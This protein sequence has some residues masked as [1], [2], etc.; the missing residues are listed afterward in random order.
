MNKRGQS[1]FLSIV[2]ALAIFMIGSLFINFITP[3]ITITRDSTHLDCSNDDISDGNKL[4]CLAVDIVV[5]Y[6]IIIILSAAGGIITA[7]FLR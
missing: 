3:E 4:S 1:L 7:R 2:V 6:F 5:P